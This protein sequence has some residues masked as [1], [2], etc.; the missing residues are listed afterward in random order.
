VDPRDASQSSGGST[1][2]LGMKTYVGA[3]LT[4]SFDRDDQRARRHNPE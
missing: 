1:T 2:Q 4:S 3:D